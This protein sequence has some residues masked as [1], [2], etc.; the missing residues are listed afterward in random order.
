MTILNISLCLP[1][2]DIVALQQTEGLQR[3]IMAVTERFIVPDKSFVLLP[4]RYSDEQN[5]SLY[6]PQIVDLLKPH[7][8]AADAPLLATHWAQCILCQLAADKEGV[9]AIAPRTIWTEPAL[10]R[11]LETRK[12]LFLSV[13]RLYPLSQAIPIETEPVCDQLYKFLP[14]P[15]FIEENARSPVLSDEAFAIAK[16]NVLTPSETIEPVEPEPEPKDILN[17]PDW[18]SK[19]AEIGNSSDGHTFEKLVRKGLIEIGFCNTLK[20]TEASLDP[21]ATG[22]AGGIDFYA[23]QPYPIVGECK[24]TETDKVKDDPATQLHKLGLKYL[25]QDEYERS[26]KIIIAAGSITKH[27]NKI[28]QGHEMNVLRPETVQ[29]LVESKID[30]T[31][32]FD[33]YPLKHCLQSE[34]FGEAADAKVD[35]Y[36]DWCWSEWQEQQEYQQLH[37]QLRAHAIQTLEELAQQPISS[38]SQEFSITEIRAHHN[39]KYQ[40]AVTDPKMQGILNQLHINKKINRR[41]YQNGPTG[42]YPKESDSETT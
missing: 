27:A 37:Q 7:A 20:R 9:E 22:G 17:S 28:A 25:E 12:K 36:L 1:E 29:R 16:E 24:A 35:K 13:L 21:D 8:Q 11:H 2:L 38:P 10:Q 18:F 40:P 30:F 26:I 41:R 15:K 23:D 3:S 5:A 42:Y 31:E 34:P 14:L 32:G 6:E 4:C 39:A 33:L 19:I